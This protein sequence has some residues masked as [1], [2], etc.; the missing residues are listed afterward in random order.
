SRT[1]ENA[2]DGFQNLRSVGKNPSAWKFQSH[3]AIAFRIVTPVFSHLHKQEEGHW[4]I[5]DFADLLARGLPDRPDRLALVA[6]NDLL[7]AVALDIDD[8]LDAHRTVLLFFPSLG[9]DMG[10]IRQ[11]LM[12]PEIK[13]FA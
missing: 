13:L 3:L 11:F 12:Q 10:R 9:L 4:L 7:L 5:Q 8:L 2:S 1:P 6:Q